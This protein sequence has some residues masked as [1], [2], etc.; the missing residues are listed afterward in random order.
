MLGRS[1]LTMPPAVEI[2]DLDA[3]RDRLRSGDGVVV[4]ADPGRPE[5]IAHV[6]T[7]RWLT[8]EN[9]ATKVLEFGNRNGRYIWFATLA[10][11][12]RQLGARRCGHCG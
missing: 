3:F 2:T 8:E 7:C 9:F 6:T 4:I 12:Q 10:D 1:L 5:P 11:A